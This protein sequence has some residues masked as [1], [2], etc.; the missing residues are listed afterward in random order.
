MIFKSYLKSILKDKTSSIIED[1]C[2]MEVNEKLKEIWKKLG[3]TYAIFT[4]LY[5]DQ[6]NDFY[7]RGTEKQINLAMDIRK[8]KI[9][10]MIKWWNHRY[11]SEKSLS[12]IAMLKKYIIQKLAYHDCAKFWIDNRENNDDLI[13]E[14]F[15]KYILSQKK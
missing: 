15:C 3:D 6:I 13:I 10:T 5:C 14:N 12:E 2:K 8:Y 1:Y 7:M 9:D 11:D 4:S